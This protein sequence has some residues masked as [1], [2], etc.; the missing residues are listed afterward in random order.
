MAQTG[1][2]KRASAYRAGVMEDQVGDGITISGQTERTQA[3]HARF[4]QALSELLDKATQ[5]I[6]IEGDESA[7][8]DL[9]PVDL[10]VFELSGRGASIPS[11]LSRKRSDLQNLLG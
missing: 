1:E 11:Y 9:H 10:T 5:A 7:E 3:A 6:E 2:R 4:Q 8:V